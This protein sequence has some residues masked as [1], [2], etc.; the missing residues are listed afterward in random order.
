M[1]NSI[2]AHLIRY[3]NEER[4][5]YDWIKKI[6]SSCTN[7]KQALIPIQN[8]IVLFSRKHRNRNMIVQLEKH[9]MKKILK[10][11]LMT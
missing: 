3:I 2:D 4:E 6:I 9:Q 1:D 8:L 5:D 10:L 11:I 7:S